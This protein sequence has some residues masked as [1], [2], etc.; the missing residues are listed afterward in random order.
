MATARSLIGRGGR[1]AWDNIAAGTTDSSLVAAVTGYKIR[2]L[3]VLLN[4]GDTT[5]SAVTFNS[6]SGGA[7]TAISPLLK[8]PANGGFVV[9]YSKQGWWESISGEGISVTTGAGSTTGVTVLY[10]RVKG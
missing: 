7:G 4:H 10:E 6:K 1:N 8:G 5:P 9:P 3:A 2:I